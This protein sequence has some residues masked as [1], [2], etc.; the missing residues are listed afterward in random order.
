MSEGNT[1]RGRILIAS[2]RSADTALRLEAVPEAA[3]RAYERR[4]LSLLQGIEGNP[5]GK[6]LLDAVVRAAAAHAVKIVAFRRAPGSRANA[7]SIANKTGATPAG[8]VVHDWE[9]NPVLDPRFTDVVTGQGLPLRGTGAGAPVFV[10]FSP[11]DFGRCKLAASQPDE[12]LFHELVH[13]YRQLRGRFRRIAL[14]GQYPNRE[15]LQ[16]TV[17]A[18]IYVSSKSSGAPLRNQY[19]L[20]EA[21][22]TWN[23][24]DSGGRQKSG[25]LRNGYT[26]S[27]T[28]MLE[29]LGAIAQLYEEER[30]LLQAINAIGCVFN[31]FREYAK[32]YGGGASVYHPA[33]H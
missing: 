6:I 15:E 13:A 24:R 1:F 11:N 29:N 14:D 12:V 18:N 2:R 26:H 19:A 23:V 22:K 5:C 4:V 21:G 25:G 20:P 9:G 8:R 28:V 16:A 32:K 10:L 27:E 31:P 7:T 30:P 3:A 17:L 33:R